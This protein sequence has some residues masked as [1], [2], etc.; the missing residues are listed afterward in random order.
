MN[1]RN[2]SIQVSNTYFP[3]Y[4]SF[5]RLTRIKEYRQSKE[6]EEPLPLEENNNSMVANGISNE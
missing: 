2:D 4:N 1:S 5:F 3:N 6:S